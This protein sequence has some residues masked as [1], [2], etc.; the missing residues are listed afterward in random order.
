MQSGS[1][2]VEEQKA[3]RARTATDE[4]GKQ[5]VGSA[6]IGAQ[7]NFLPSIGEGSY[8]GWL[9]ATGAWWDETIVEVRSPWR[10][11]AVTD[12]SRCPRASE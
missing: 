8:E 2:A 9:R 3:K 11:Y 7:G 5:E 6:M 12:A 4:K 1:S 10:T